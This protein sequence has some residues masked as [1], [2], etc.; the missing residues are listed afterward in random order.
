MNTAQ[1][2]Q[3]GFTIVELL[4]VIVVIGIL[5][6]IALVSYNGVQVKAQ[7]AKIAADV[8]TLSQAV[9]LARTVT[10]S[11]LMVIDGIPDAAHSTALMCARLPTGTDLATVAKTD[12]CWA[13]YIASLNAISVA[14]GM[15]V[16]GLLDPFGRPYL[17]DENEG[18][19]S[20]CRQD[21]IAVYPKPFVTGYG[22]YPLTPLENVSRSGF[23]AGC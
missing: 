4:I 18:E 23:V 20:L 13:T 22:S 3:S 11:T 5:A 12:T 10:G 2:K 6:A 8:S 16:R 17:I 21:S 19:D 9:V 1:Q 15:N 7:N 14:S